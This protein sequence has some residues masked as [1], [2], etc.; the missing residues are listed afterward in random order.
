MQLFGPK[1]RI[2]FPVTG[3]QINDPICF[4]CYLVHIDEIKLML[5]INVVA[6]T[7]KKDL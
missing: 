4:L 1:D 3:F 6:P 2:Q 5:K 7:P